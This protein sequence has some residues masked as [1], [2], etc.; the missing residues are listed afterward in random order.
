M[1]DLLS[2]Q[3]SQSDVGPPATS[4]HPQHGASSQR[5]RNV[6][7][8]LAARAPRFGQREPLAARAGWQVRPY[9]LPFRYQR[10]DVPAARTAPQSAH[11]PSRFN[12]MIMAFSLAPFGAA[13][14]AGGRR[15]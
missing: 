1:A 15:P 11:A 8:A 6:L 2:S 13:H 12:V 7:G 5:P 3:S 4:Q 14:L 9:T 10:A